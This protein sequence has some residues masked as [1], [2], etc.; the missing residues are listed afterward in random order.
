MTIPESETSYSGR[1][2]LEAMK[3]A[4]RYNNFLLELIRKYSTGKRT[5]D[6][7]AGAGHA[8]ACKCAIACGPAQRECTD[9]ER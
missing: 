1:D 6:H 7:G 5:L 9:P 3:R 4:T 8:R 2:N